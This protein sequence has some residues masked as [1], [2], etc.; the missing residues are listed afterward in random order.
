MPDN[1]TKRNSTKEVVKI[2]KLTFFIAFALA[3][4]I[5]ISSQI[6]SHSIGSFACSF[7]HSFIHTYT[8]LDDIISHIMP[9]PL[10]LNRRVKNAVSLFFNSYKFS[11]WE[12]KTHKK[13][14]LF[15]SW[16]IQ[17]RIFSDAIFGQQLSWICI[18]ADC[19]DETY[20]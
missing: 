4:A 13:V 10:L 7:I 3:I 14:E 11:R 12:S 20:I 2:S 9:L 18:M 5:S 19:L 6:P 8:H 16:S 15:I 1:S 17:R